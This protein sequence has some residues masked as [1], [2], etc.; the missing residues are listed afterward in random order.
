M[1]RLCSIMIFT[2]RMIIKLIAV[3]EVAIKLAEV[4]VE[5]LIAI[6]L[7]QQFAD[8]MAVRPATISR[9]H[10]PRSMDCISDKVG[11]EF[12]PLCFLAFASSV[13]RDWYATIA[14]PVLEVLV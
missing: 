10:P 8:C 11:I 4:C 13:L 14:F 5:V 12:G 6:S 1:V 9:V 7:Q 2:T 3:S